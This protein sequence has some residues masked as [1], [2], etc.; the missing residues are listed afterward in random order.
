MRDNAVW[1]VGVVVVGLAGHAAWL[2]RGQGQLAQRVSALEA[3][4]SEVPGINYM[5]SRIKALDAQVQGVSDQ[6]LESNYKI[7]ALQSMIDTLRSTMDRI[8]KQPTAGAAS[9]SP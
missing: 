3:M 5:D 2:H 1:I 7:G 4:L 9:T 8:V 6:V